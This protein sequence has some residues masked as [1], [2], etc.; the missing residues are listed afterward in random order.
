MTNKKIGNT[1][2]RTFAKLMF[3]EGWWVH[4]I[5]DKLNGQPFDLIMSKNNVTWFLDIK[6]IKAG[7]DYFPLD[8]IEENQRNAMKLLESCGTSK[9]GFAFYFEDDG[10]FLIQ[11]NNIDYERKR[12]HKSEMK[13]LVFFNYR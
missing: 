10:W 13:R 12:V 7:Q 2:E 6:H 5:A 11:N 3:K 4:L 9:T 8:R 1:T